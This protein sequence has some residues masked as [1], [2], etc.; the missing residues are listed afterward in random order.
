EIERLQYELNLAQAKAQVGA[1]EAE[2]DL[3]R[4]RI[5]SQRS[6]VGVAEANVAAARARLDEATQ[7][8]RRLE[9]LPPKR[10]VTP[11]AVD[12]ARTNKAAAESALR[13][14]QSATRESEEVVGDVN[15]LLAQLEGA[16]AVVG[17]AERDLRNTVV[18]A[19][20]DGRI[21]GVTTSLGQLV[22]PARA[23]FT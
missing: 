18:R 6:A 19:P 12:T 21:I 22:G 20:F 16:R 1:L 23:L 5:S 11:Q 9:P 14:A 10:Y 3:T 4:R 8:L 13:G 15:T 7:T 17:N 2:I